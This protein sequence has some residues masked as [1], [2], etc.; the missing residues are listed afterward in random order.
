[1]HLFDVKRRFLGGTAI[2]G[3]GLPLASGIAFSIV[4]RGG[5]QICLCFFGDGAVNEGAFHETLNIDSL[6]SL[7]ILFVCENNMYAMGTRVDRACA[8]P[9]MYQRAEC[10]AMDVHSVDGMDLM[11]VYE[12]A[13][14]T[15]RQV[16]EKKRPIF[17]EAVTYRFRGHSMSDPGAYRTKEEIEEWRRRDPIVHFGNILLSEGALTPELIENILTD[18]DREIEE[19]VEFAQLSPLPAPEALLQD[20]YA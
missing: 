11:A 6:W 12:M 9:N 17:V 15:M 4:Y 5:D 8:V 16:R 10:Y 7:P 2:V 1:M 20:I 3:G 18:V 13:E 19:A 14:R